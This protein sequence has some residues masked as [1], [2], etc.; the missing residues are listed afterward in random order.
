MT[1]TTLEKAHTCFIEIKKSKFIA[2]ASPIDSVASAMKFIE[3]NKDLDATHNTW[4]YKL[5]REYRFNDDGEVGGTAGKPILN[6]IERQELDKVVVMVIRYYGGTKLGVGGL[7][8]AYGGAASECLKDAIKLVVKPKTIVLIK[9]S[10]DLLGVA[11][12]IFDKF[13]LTKLNENYKADGV[14]LTSEIEVDKLELFKKNL[15]DSS[16]GKALVK[17]DL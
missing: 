1:F 2:K 11:Y 10:F 15:R 6:A 8:R 9:I 12:K 13:N 16:L 3:E 4:A 7:L 5:G 17:S 14:E